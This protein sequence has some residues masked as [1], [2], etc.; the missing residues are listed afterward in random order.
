MHMLDT[1]LYIYIK[2]DIGHIYIFIFT[3]DESNHDY[4]E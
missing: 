4:L 3:E 1:L 2:Y